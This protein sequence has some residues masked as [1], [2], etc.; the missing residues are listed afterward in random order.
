VR[1]MMTK[2]VTMTTI[3]AAKIV[4]KN[5]EVQAINQEPVTLLGNVS[6]EKAQKR[7]NKF[8]G[9]P[10]TILEV[11][12]DTITYEA[13]VEEFLKIAKIKSRTVQA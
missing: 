13:P 10:M 1:K 12:A 6:M 7:C 3:K 2:E 4:V 11:I 9:E 5:G 8:F